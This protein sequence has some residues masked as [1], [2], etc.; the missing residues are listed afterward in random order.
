MIDLTIDMVES[1]APKRKK[2]PGAHAKGA[3]A[4]RTVLDDLVS[5]YR[6]GRPAAAE[7]H[8]S[9]AEDEEPDAQ[10][11]CSG[12]AEACEPDAS[13]VPDEPDEPAA[14]D[15]D[16]PCPNP[17]AAPD[18][19]AAAGRG[20]RRAARPCDG[21]PEPAGFEFGI[22]WDDAFPG[23]AGC[24]AFARLLRDCPGYVFHPNAAGRVYEAAS[25]LVGR[26]CR[27][28]CARVSRQAMRVVV[29]TGFRVHPGRI[30]EANVFAMLANG[31][32]RLRGFSP[33]G[34]D[35]A[36]RFGFCCGTDDPERLGHLLDLA[37]VS[38]EDALRPFLLVSQGTSA[39]HAFA[40]YS[41]RCDEL[42]E[43]D[44]NTECD[45]DFAP[46]RRDGKD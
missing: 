23:A 44:L 24:V 30:F 42:D 8:S 41:G 16:A 27:I 18:G 10:A 2:P 46:P 4:P 33:I 6:K 31:I 3:D 26:S 36:V 39:Q 21:G 13:S 17:A 15:E 40:L 1:T 7:A 9:E 28:E 22:S 35:G 20:P 43:L 5:R 45:D 25:P 12:G 34:A 38:C 11:S 19:A 37:L 32:L 14:P 29:D